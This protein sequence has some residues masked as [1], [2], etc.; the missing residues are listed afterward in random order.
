VVSLPSAL[1]SE[2][3]YSRMIARRESGRRSSDDCAEKAVVDRAF[4]LI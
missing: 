3:E 2:D 1:G 4:A